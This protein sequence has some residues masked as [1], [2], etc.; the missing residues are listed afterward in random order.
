MDQVSL[1]V[2]CEPSLGLD[3]ADAETVLVVVVV[4]EFPEFLLGQPTFAHLLLGHLRTNT[5][6]QSPVTLRVRKTRLRNLMFKAEFRV[7]KNH[8]IENT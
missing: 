2:L 5:A 7:R 1:V 8:L 3:L 6:H 4:E